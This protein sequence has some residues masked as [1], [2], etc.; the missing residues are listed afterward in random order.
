MAENERT[1]LD[2]VLKKLPPEDAGIIVKYVV[3][4]MNDTR[5]TLKHYLPEI[6]DTTL[7]RFGISGSV[8][9][10]LGEIATETG[11]GFEDVLLKALVLYK[12]AV[13]A[14]RKGQRLVIVGPDYRLI[15]EIVEID[16]PVEEPLSSSGGV[17]QREAS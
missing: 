4:A 6:V 3:D 16:S 10:E 13:E 17:K 11:E 8:M 5:S 1:G 7:R 15:R 14:T 2:E 12:A 9:R